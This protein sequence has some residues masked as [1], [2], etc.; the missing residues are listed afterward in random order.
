MERKTEEFY[1]KNNPFLPG[2]G[3]WSLTHQGM[4]TRD[5]PR[6]ADR[7]R[8]EAEEAK[9]AMERR[10]S[11]TKL[12]WE[13]LASAFPEIRDELARLRRRVSADNTGRR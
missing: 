1:R 11:D 4:V 9:S 13:C 3:T 8:A 5:F 2:D 10:K 6:L 12:S 7:L